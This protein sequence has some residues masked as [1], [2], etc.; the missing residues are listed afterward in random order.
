[1]ER[2]LGSN[3]LAH[4]VPL[5]VT[6]GL[7]SSS[8]MELSEGFSPNNNESTAEKFLE[9]LVMELCWSKTEKSWRHNQHLLN[10]FSANLNA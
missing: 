4:I 5:K 1:M 3:R 6:D 10:S 9:Q 2:T 7:F 8:T